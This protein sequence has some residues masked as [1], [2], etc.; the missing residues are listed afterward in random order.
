M[1]DESRE[2]AF[3]KTRHLVKQVDFNLAQREG[4]ELRHIRATDIT[5]A[6]KAALAE[7]G[8][9]AN[10]EG[11]FPERALT[12]RDYYTILSTVSDF[13]PQGERTNPKYLSSPEDFTSFLTR[14]NTSSPD[15]PLSNEL[16]DEVK[17]WRF[18]VR[19][20]G[21]GRERKI[22]LT[23]EPGSPIIDAMRDDVWKKLTDAGLPLVDTR[24][25]YK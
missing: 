19:L 8:R 13:I 20:K 17:L 4:K 23:V 16:G 21:M 18:K 6:G 25:G 12:H 14:G 9:K 3:S 15:T 7:I 24:W 10:S 5:S 11:V 1:N 22:A 2:D